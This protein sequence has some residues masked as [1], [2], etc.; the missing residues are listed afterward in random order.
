VDHF[1]QVLSDGVRNKR[2]N[3][4]KGRTTMAEAGTRTAQVQ[5]TAT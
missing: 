1:G 4:R 5:S 3:M 2:I